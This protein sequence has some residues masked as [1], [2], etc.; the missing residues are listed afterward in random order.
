MKRTVIALSLLLAGIG[1]ANAQSAGENAQR[2]ADQQQRI[3]QGLQSGQLNTRETGRLERYYTALADTFERLCPG[4]MVVALRDVIAD[5]YAD[6][7]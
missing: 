2:D 4:P 1:A 5:T 6:L 7:S 3:E